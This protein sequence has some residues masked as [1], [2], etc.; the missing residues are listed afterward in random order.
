MIFY[1]E[2]HIRVL[3]KANSALFEKYTLKLAINKKFL[4]KL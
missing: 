3:G 2:Y 1:H 4:P